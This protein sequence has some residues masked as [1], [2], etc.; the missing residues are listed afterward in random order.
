[1]RG[2]W[3]RVLALV[4][5]CF[6][7]GAAAADL[8]EG[9]DFIELNPPLATERGTIEV[10]EFFWY[11]CPHC[12]N[13][14]ALLTPW[15]RKLPADVSFR[16]VPAIFPKSPKW[17]RDARTYYT[18][19]S[20]NLL[21]RLHGEVFKAIHLERKRLDDEKVLLDW[22]PGQGVDANAFRATSLSFAV[23]SRVR[24]AVEVT[25]RAGLTG[26]PAVVVD[27]RYQAIMPETLNDL[28]PIVDRLIERARSERVRK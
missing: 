13:F 16:R 8:R 2:T 3:S 10:T 5:A 27:G 23:Q 26:V 4:T 11:G 6:C 21:D 15:I 14:E 19:E 18:L 1:M 22:I 20:M 25:Q 9:R 28:L 12:F 17:A 7:V 24:Q